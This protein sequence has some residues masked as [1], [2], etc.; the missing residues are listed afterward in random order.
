MKECKLSTDASPKRRVKKQNMAAEAQPTVN[1]ARA[2]LKAV[3]KAKKF[4]TGWRV[5]G[6]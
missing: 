5:G 3:A 6:R 1:N 4:V 2:M